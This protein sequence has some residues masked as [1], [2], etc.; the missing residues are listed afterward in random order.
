[1]RRRSFIASAAGAAAASALGIPRAR[2]G[3]LDVLKYKALVPEIFQP[4]A[5]PPT[6]SDVVVIGSGFGGAVAALRLAE[7]GVSVTMLERGSR[8]PSSPKRATFTSDALPD[9]RGFWFR[10]SFTGV[11]GIPQFFDS[12]GGVLDVTSYAGID[13]WRG[14]AV[15]GGSVVYTGATVQPE[16]RFFDAVFGGRV[17]YD[18][19]DAEYYPR[20]R[21]MLG[22]SLMPADIYASGPFTHSRTWDAQAEKTGYVPQP[23]EGNWN[24]NTVRAELAGTVRKSATVGE[25]NLGNANGVK[26]DL[27]QNYLKQAEAT[28]RLSI[29]PGHTVTSIGR[30]GAGRYTISV[31]KSDPTGRQLLT[32]TLTANRLVLGAGSVGTSELLVRAKALGTLPLLNEY[33]GAGWGTNGDAAVV[34]SVAWNNLLS[35]QGVP[36]RSRILDEG[37]DLPVT[38]ENWY[39]PLLPLDIGLIGSLAMTLDPTRARFHYDRATSRVL[40]DWQKTDSR[41]SVAAIRVVNDRIARANG[42]ASGVP[43]VAPD[44]NASFTAHPLGGAV[45]GDVTDEYGRVKG[46]PGLYVLDGAL[47]PGNTGT[48]NPSLTIA[49]LAERN[50][51]AIVDAGY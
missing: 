1:M 14:A 27:T 22:S 15:G 39:V 32:R 17:D 51:D 48:V 28:G 23:I 25:S 29:Y 24:W 37:G 8:W 42:L 44:V 49:A 18:E 46:Y 2:A 43:L 47:I 9:G 19:L 10:N 3:F 33:V 6:H 40:L 12:F 11:S 26:Q 31:R 50:I 4:L 41:R 5:D 34:R 45:I 16:R 13:V 7:A 20:V 30:D 36:S 21:A 38:L 35:A